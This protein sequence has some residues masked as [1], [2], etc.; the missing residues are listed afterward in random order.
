MAEHLPR[1]PQQI[2][3][4]QQLQMQ[5]LRDGG[6]RGAGF[7]QPALMAVATAAEAAFSLTNFGLY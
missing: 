7:E 6:G 5:Q 1:V 4:H 2:Q 3:P